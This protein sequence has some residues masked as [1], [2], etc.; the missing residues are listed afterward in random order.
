[1]LNALFVVNNLSGTVSKYNIS[2][3]VEL[4]LD[5]DKFQYSFFYIDEK[6]NPNDYQAIFEINY[7][8]IVSVGGDGTLLEIGQN[9]INQKTIL[10]IVPIGS[11]NGLATHLGYK[12]RN[13]E[14]A[15]DAIN[16][17][18]VV[19]IDAAQIN[20]S[21]FFSNFGYGIDAKIAK[22]FK[23]KKNRGFLVYSWLTVKR[24]FKLK[25][26]KVAYKIHGETFK[27]QTYL[28]N[29]FNSNLFGYNVGLI[30]WASAFDQKL[31]LVYLKKFPFWKLPYISFCI[32][33][34]K[35]QWIKEMVYQEME[36]IE[37][38]NNKGKMK[39]Q[40]DGDPKITKENLKIKIIPKALRVVKPL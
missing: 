19:E 13:I 4:N 20:E 5:T 29:V 7:D 28:F 30:P 37:I 23:T 6:T 14:Q 8:V 39:Y 24:F 2:K 35:P 12:P 33:I 38:I 25:T 32:L 21:Y 9:L 34:K 40:V 17:L 22:D 10:G 27:V 16:R 18:E 1:M 15:F 3:I 11:G 31:D 26:Q 36:E